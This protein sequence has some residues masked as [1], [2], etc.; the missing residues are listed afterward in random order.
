MV[1]KMA[2]FGFVHI[3]F[4]LEMWKKMNPTILNTLCKVQ[5]M[6]TKQ[7]WCQCSLYSIEF[8][9]MVIF[10]QRKRTV[11]E[12]IQKKPFL[13]AARIFLY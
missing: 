2:S 13:A 8:H 10:P 11:I 4:F 5:G 6:T 9:C 1:E 12:S 7:S 3:T